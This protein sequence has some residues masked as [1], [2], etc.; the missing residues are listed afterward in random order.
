MNTVVVPLYQ[1]PEFFEIWMEILQQAKGAKE[2]MYVFCLDFGYDK[3]HEALIKKFPYACGIIR[4]PA[5]SYK[6]AKQSNNVLNGLLV[7]AANSDELVYYIEEDIFIAKDFFAWHKEVHRQQPGIFCSIATRN[8]NT[9]FKTDGILEHYYLSRRPDYQAL[10]TCFRREVIEKFIRPHFTEAYL[11]DPLGYC[12]SRFPSSVIGGFYVEQDGLI[13][14]IIEEEKKPVAFPHVPRAFHGG[15]WGYNRP[16]GQLPRMTY[17]QRLQAIRDIAF[18]REM[19]KKY[20]KHPGYYED[21]EPC[22]LETTFEYLELRQ[23]LDI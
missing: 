10:G 21:S 15:I 20:V 11:R 7:G 5:T 9:R 19:L 22:D 18:D 14:R 6:L 23:P 17:E 13:R 1:R 12:K 4:M 2:N 3:R 16:N 8:N